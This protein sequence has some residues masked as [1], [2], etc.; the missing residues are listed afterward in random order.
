MNAANYCTIRYKFDDRRTP[1]TAQHAIYRVA[2]L[3]PTIQQPARLRAPDNLHTPAAS[4]LTYAHV[5]P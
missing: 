3:G 1:A 4:L 2:A 5:A